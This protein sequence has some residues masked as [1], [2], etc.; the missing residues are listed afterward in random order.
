MLPWC[1]KE[2]LRVRGSEEIGKFGGQRSGRERR[3]NS[4]LHAFDAHR[5]NTDEKIKESYHLS[6]IFVVKLYVSKI[7]LVFLSINEGMVISRFTR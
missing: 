5:I 4:A 1:G 7:R 2:L 6:E 3:T